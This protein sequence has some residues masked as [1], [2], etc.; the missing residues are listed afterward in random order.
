MSAR[1][2]APDEEIGAVRLSNWPFPAVL[3]L[4]PASARGLSLS[5]RLPMMNT[6]RLFERVPIIQEG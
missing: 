6:V 5:V 4:S 1:S 2:Y 3:S